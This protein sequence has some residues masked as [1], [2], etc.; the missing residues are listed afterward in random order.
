M[1]MS[2]NVVV[3]GVSIG[4][5]TAALAQARYRCRDLHSRTSSERS[6]ASNPL[7]GT[8]PV[9]LGLQAALAKV[10][11]PDAAGSALQ[12]RRNLNW[13]DL[14]DKSIERSARRI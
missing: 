13:F 5:L 11:R 14:G 7:N 12:H 6:A 8:R 9:A 4:G 2:K 10:R 1:T 3:I